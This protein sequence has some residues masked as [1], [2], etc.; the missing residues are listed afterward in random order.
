MS[1]DG[2]VWAVWARMSPWTNCW[3]A[4]SIAI[5][6]LAKIRSPAITACE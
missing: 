6:P 3:V 1:D 4:G 5:W 2:T